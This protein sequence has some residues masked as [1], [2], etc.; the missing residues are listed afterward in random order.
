MSVNTVWILITWGDGDDW[1]ELDVSASFFLVCKIQLFPWTLPMFIGHKLQ[2]I[3][4]K[5]KKKKEVIFAYLQSHP[6]THVQNWVK[7][8]YQINMNIYSLNKAFFAC[9]REIYALFAFSRHSWPTLL[10][11]SSSLPIMSSVSHS[12]FK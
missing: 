10:T 8:C 3:K 1:D 6:W 5:I 7:L 2:L 11:L 12:R 4:T 9:F